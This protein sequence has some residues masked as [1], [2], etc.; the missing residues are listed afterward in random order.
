M[1]GK[2]AVIGNPSYGKAVGNYGEIVGMDVFLNKPEECKLIMFTGGDDVSPNMYGDQSPLGI[3]SSDIVRDLEEAEIFDLALKHGIKMTGICRG[4]QFLHVMAGGKLMH[5]IER[6][7]GLAHTL[8]CTT[9]DKIIEV[10]S[11]HHQMMIPNAN[12]NVIAWS[13]TQRSSKYI[14]NNDVEVYYKGPEVEAV[15]WPDI[16]AAGVQYHPEWMETSSDGYKWYN[17]MIG[18]LLSMKTDNFVKKYIR[19]NWPA[20]EKQLQ[21]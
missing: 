6:H 12:S 3:C 5:H 21:Y 17:E 14:G 15:I 10:N 9:N 11:Y 8:Q 19:L 18:H 7:A 13:D 4:A 20:G 1:K 2:I 16:N